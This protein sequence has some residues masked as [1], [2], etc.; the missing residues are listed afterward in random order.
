MFLERKNFRVKIF[1]F[2]GNSSVAREEKS[3][4]SWQRWKFP[5]AFIKIK[6]TKNTD[7]QFSSFSIHQ[8]RFP[9]AFKFNFSPNVFLLPKNNAEETYS[10]LFAS[11]WRTSQPRDNDYHV[12]CVK[13]SLAFVRNEM[14]GWMVCERDGDKIRKENCF[15]N[16]NNFPTL[17]NKLLCCFPWKF[18]FAFK[19]QR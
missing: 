12:G 8:S 15:P 9:H 13:F 3:F 2:V 1:Q 6:Q 18:C 19:A 4:V 14:F 5:S 10:P 16:L 11:F 7:L 17:T